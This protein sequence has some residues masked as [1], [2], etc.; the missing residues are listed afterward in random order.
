[1][2]ASPVDA[3][4]SGRPVREDEVPLLAMFVRRVS[5]IYSHL[6]VTDSSQVHSR[7]VL[8]SYEEMR[9]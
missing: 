6:S 9:R 8:R 5:V 7:M 2:S 4:A 1:M 3:T